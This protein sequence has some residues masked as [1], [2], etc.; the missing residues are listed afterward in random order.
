MPF[1]SC[2]VEREVTSAQQTN[3]PTPAIHPDRIMG[4]HDFLYLIE[5]EWEVWNE[6]TPYLLHP[7]DLLILSAGR[8]HFG[9]ILNKPGTKIFYAH[10]SVAKGDNAPETTGLTGIELPT[11]VEC[12][13]APGVLSSFRELVN[14]F[15]S[16][17]PIRDIHLNAQFE[18]LL[19]ELSTASAIGERPLHGIAEQAKSILLADP[20]GEITN[21]EL[22]K[23]L[24]V[25]A[26]RLRYVFEQ[27]IGLPPYRYHMNLRLDMAMTTIRTDPERTF[28]DLAEQFG[29]CDEFHFS[30]AFKQRF[31]IPP[32]KVKRNYP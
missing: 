6:N 8:R 31:G 32:S 17:S 25:S 9:R 23:S 18:L 7:G 26:R 12:A 5:G 27:E 15:W 20:G 10:T 29:F 16:N 3:Y 19:C 21:D 1:F 14:I 30:R 22:A 24:G 11:L 4:E 13:E 28:R 2:K